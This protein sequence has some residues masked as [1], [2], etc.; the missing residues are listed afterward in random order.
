MTYF[1]KFNCQEKNVVKVLRQTDR[2]PEGTEDYSLDVSRL[3][4]QETYITRKKE[5][6]E[7]PKI[8]SSNQK[9]RK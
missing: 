5:I 3:T 1:L 6:T 2:R 9:Y 8:L 7:S 4:D